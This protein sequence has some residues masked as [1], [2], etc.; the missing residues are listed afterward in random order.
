V[1][2]QFQAKSDVFM[3]FGGTCRQASHREKRHAIGGGAGHEHYGYSVSYTTTIV[4]PPA[5]VASLVE[6]IKELHT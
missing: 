5:L 6:S 1:A 2:G 4:Q 3:Q